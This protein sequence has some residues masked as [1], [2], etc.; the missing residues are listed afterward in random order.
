MW[1]SSILT[2]LKWN[3]PRCECEKSVSRLFGLCPN[4]LDENAY[5]FGSD[6]RYLFS[7]CLWRRG[8]VA[9][10]AAG[11][12]LGA[13]RRC[14]TSFSLFFFSLVYALRYI[15]KLNDNTKKT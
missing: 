9:T 3:L 2:K 4:Y 10:A 14:Q 15:V 11:G 6:L 8:V 7:K 5:M 1:I 12:A 13:M